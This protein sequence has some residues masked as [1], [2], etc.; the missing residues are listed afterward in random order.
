M[1]VFASMASVAIQVSAAK[2]VS[3]PPT[4]KGKRTSSRLRDVAIF[5]AFDLLKIGDA[6][7]VLDLYHDKN[8][9]GYVSQ[10]VTALINAK[11]AKRTRKHSGPTPAKYVKT[12]DRPRGFAA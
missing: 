4:V 7:E 12:A 1:N 5:A 3:D 9:R 6:F 8:A 11:C 2:A 10:V